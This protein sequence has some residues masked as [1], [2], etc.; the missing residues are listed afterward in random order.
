M[1][2]LYAKYSFNTPIFKKNIDIYYLF[3]TVVKNNSNNILINKNFIF[4]LLNKKIFYV[5][6]KIRRDICTKVAIYNNVHT[7]ILSTIKSHG[8]SWLFVSEQ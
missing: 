3:S 1:V 4:F 5:I 8:Y 7:K 6:V 2:F